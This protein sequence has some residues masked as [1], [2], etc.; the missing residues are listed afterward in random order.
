M[1]HHSI[2]FQYILRYHGT[3]FHWASAHTF[4]ILFSYFFHTVPIL[5]FFQS[6][7]WIWLTPRLVIVIELKIMSAGHFS[8]LDILNDQTWL[9]YFSHFKH[10]NFNKTSTSSLIRL[11]RL[12]LQFQTVEQAVTSRRDHAT[13]KP[14]IRTV[15][16]TLFNVLTLVRPLH[17]IPTEKSESQWWDILPYTV[18]PRIF[19]KF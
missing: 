17:L 15:F 1:G 2:E 6:Q 13:G 11:I 18:E 8:T 19:R 4:L 16:S 9:T 12:W 3:S 7:L 14:L 10:M 5:K